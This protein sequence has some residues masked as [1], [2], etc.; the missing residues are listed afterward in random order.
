MDKNKRRSGQFG[1]NFNS[2]L[3]FYSR[4]GI[5]SGNSDVVSVPFGHPTPTVRDESGLRTSGTRVL[6][7][8]LPATPP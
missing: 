2:F 5:V 7:P 3:T 1:S 8:R 4:I 6:P